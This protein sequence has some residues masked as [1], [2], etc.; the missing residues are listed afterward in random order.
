MLWAVVMNRR[1]FITGK[2]MRDL[3]SGPGRSPE[4]KAID[5]AVEIGGEAAAVALMLLLAYQGSRD[6]LES[7]RIAKF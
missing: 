4:G 2:W 6:R 5:N 7:K 3:V 1:D